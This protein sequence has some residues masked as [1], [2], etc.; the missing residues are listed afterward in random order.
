RMFYAG[1]VH[2][3]LP[4]PDR[5]RQ[6]QQLPYLILPLPQKRFR[7]DDEDVATSPQTHQLGSE[8][9]LHCLSQPNLISQDKPSTSALVCLEGTLHEGFLMCPETVLSPVDR[10]L[11]G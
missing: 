4:G 5:R 1:L 10:Q 9:K 8:R 3:G 11:D 6:V 7:D 2:P